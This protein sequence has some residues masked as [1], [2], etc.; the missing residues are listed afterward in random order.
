MLF[1]LRLLLEL[2]QIEMVIIFVI[3]RRLNHRYLSLLVRIL[4]LQA[5]EAGLCLLFHKSH[6]RLLLWRV[7]GVNAAVHH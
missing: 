5:V 7:L 2:R 6:R 1:H 3:R 4:A